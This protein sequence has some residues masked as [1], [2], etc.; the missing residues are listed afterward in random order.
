MPARVTDHQRIQAGSL[1]LPQLAL[2]GERKPRDLQVRVSGKI[3]IRSAEDRGVILGGVFVLRPRGR[4]R[5]NS[6][7]LLLLLPASYPAYQREH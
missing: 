5:R 6:Y 7:P 4:K 1:D 2:P 3:P